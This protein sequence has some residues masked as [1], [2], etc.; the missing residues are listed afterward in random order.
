MEEDLELVNRCLNK[1]ADAFA[2]IVDK[3]QKPIYNLGMRM[4]GNSDDAEDLT[5]S[6]FIKSWERLDSYDSKYK[7]FSWLYRIAVNESINYSKREKIKQSLD[8]EPADANNFFEIE[9]EKN[10]LSSKIHQALLGID[11]N[12]RMVIVLKHYME[13][14][15]SE[16]AELTQIPEKTVKSRLFSARQL[17]KNILL[18]EGILNNE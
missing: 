4:F 15:Y 11:I 12:Y 14:S 3:Y 1:E 6:V 8:D 5:Q 9:C 7:F 16:V 10:D 2:K 17:L 13:L 18:K